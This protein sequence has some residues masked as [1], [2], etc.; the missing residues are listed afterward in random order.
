MPK[1]T[2]TAKTGPAFPESVVAVEVLAGGGARTT[3]ANAFDP[4]PKGSASIQPI[5]PEEV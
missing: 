5:W 1:T 3:W 4:M 2:I